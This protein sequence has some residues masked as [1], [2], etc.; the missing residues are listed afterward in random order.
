MAVKQLSILARNRKG[1]LRKIIDI[2]AASGADLRSICIADTED[3]G[4]LRVISDKP[5]VAVEALLDAGYTARVRKVVAIAVEDR[6][7][8]LAEALDI[9]DDAGI[10]L[11]YMYSVINGEKDK[12]YMVLRVD[13]NARTEAIFR[14][15]GIQVLQEEDI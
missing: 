11:E 10:N 2:I 7:G 15:A 8:A 13:D 1:S 5:D 12:A 4:I 14:E 6:P 3:F 9:L